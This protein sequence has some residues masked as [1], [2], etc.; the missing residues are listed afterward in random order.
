MERIIDLDDG[1]FSQC[2]QVGNGINA[3]LHVIEHAAR[4][5]PLL[6]FD[7]DAPAAGTGGGVHMFDA[8]DLLNRFLDLQHDGFLD[9]IR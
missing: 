3:D 6:H 8:T 7:E 9:F 4:V 1:L 5:E 2:R